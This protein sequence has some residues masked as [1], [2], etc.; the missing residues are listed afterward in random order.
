MPM[1]MPMPM[2]I[3]DRRWLPTRAAPLAAV[4]AVALA[5]GL[6]S[7]YCGHLFACGC[8]WPGLG[9]DDGCAFFAGHLDACPWCA[10]PVATTILL[11]A[12]ALAGA[13]LA[14]GTA[15]ALTRRQ[16]PGLGIA[17]GAVGGALAFLALAQP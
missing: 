6:T 1:P 16:R 8:T 17:L 12:A 9:L 7:P 5:V 11:A 10:R 3:P 13:G 2:P 15:L 4:A 14:G